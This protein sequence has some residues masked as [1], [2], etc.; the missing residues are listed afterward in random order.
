MKRF[1]CIIVTALMALSVFAGPRHR[2]VVIDTI[3]NAPM[4]EMLKT[5]LRFC[6]QFQS[7][8][9]SLFDW[10]YMGLR[11]DETEVEKTKESRDVIQ[12]RYKDR[13]YD[14]VQRTGDVAIDIYVLGV[15]WWKDQH[16]GTKHTLTRPANA[17][18]PLTSR[19]VATYSG[20]I[21]EEA[22]CIIRMTPLSENQ[23][24]VH[25]EF[26]FAFGRVLAAFI[27]D[28]TWENAIEWRFHVILENLIEYAETGKVEPRPLQGPKK[29]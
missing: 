6:R 9:D 20:S 13:T 7:A 29:K 22:D 26:N 21:L 10:A 8:P 4:S 28:K 16:L 24:K 12:L 3:C 14:P 25:Y 1:I 15:R 18:Y 19:M 5:S 17:Q 23:T 11:E 27:S 2:S